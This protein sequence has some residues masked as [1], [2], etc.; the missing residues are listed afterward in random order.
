MRAELDLVDLTRLE[1]VSMPPTDDLF[2]VH[3]TLILVTPGRAIWQYVKH[4]RRVCQNR[5]PP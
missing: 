5:G 4:T 2:D 1:F 3:V